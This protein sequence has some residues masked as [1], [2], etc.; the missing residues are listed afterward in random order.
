MKSRD[1]EWMLLAKRGSNVAFEQLVKRHYSSVVD[2][3]FWRLWD[4]D[5]AQDLAQ[6]V[7]LKLYNALPNYQ[8]Q[9]PFRGYLFSIATNQLIDHFRRTKAKPP[10]ISL[11]R[12]AGPA[13]GG[14]GGTEEDG[15]G[16]TLLDALVADVELVDARLDRAEILAGVQE[17][18]AT[19]PE[20]QYLVF[21]LHR[22]EDRSYEQIA[23]ELG[24][25]IGTVKSRM[26]AAYTRLRTTLRRIL[27][28][29]ADDLDPTDS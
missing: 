24:I 17:A 12:R 19:L 3:F 15:E 16:T 27:P 26:N 8:P 5:Q 6:E 9:G 4:R 25:P 7:F 28:S 10:P 21:V 14:A 29:H 22:L 20:E 18:V 1:V 2:F 11:D 13:G 23:E